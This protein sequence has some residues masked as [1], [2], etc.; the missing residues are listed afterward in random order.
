VQPDHPIA[1]NNLAY[2]LLE[3]SGNVDVALSLAQVARRAMPEFPSTADTLAWAYYRKGTYGLAVPLL[4]DALKNQPQNPTYHFHLG[5]TYSKMNDR[6]RARTHLEKVLQID[7][8]Y[9]QGDQV[10][11]ALNDLG[12]S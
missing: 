5:M 11:Q 8:K 2:L 1:A 7:P 3:Q 4:E 6:K 12:K 10:R 9:P